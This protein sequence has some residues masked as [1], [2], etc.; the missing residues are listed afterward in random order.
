MIL[1]NVSAQNYTASM[2]QCILKKTAL[3]SIKKLSQTRCFASFKNSQ[4]ISVIKASAK[5]KK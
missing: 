4:K 5:A 3:Y 1:A 2:Y